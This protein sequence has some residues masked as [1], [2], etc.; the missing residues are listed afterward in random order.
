M[1]DVKHVYEIAHNFFFAWKAA[2]IISSVYILIYVLRN[3]TFFYCPM[4]VYI[5]FILKSNNEALNTNSF[6]IK[7]N[8]FEKY[9][10]GISFAL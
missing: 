9:K 10:S 6:M 2:F 5:P 1:I 4:R 8:L 3:N 7:E